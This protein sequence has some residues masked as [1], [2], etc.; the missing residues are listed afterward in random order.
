MLAHAIGLGL[1]NPN[2]GPVQMLEDKS[3]WEAIGYTVE[4]GKLQ[5]GEDVVIYRDPDNSPN[6]IYEIYNKQELITRHVFQD[7]GAELRL[8]CRTYQKRY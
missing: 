8:D 7:R 5:K 4:S 2:G 6:R 3:Y 1:H